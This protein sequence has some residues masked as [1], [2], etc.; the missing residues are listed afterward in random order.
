MFLKYATFNFKIIMTFSLLLIVQ[1]L[2]SQNNKI[3]SLTIV[4][5]NHKAKD[6]TR[7]GILYQM[8]FS[9]F[10]S[11]EKAAK[12]Y[13]QEAEQLSNSLNY[14]KGKADVLQMKGILESRKS[15]YATSDKYFFKALEIY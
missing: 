11:D 2:Y 1:L 10:H 12:K 13:I 6:T 14:P 5:Q 7:V 9:T 8:A 15:N 4:L 3:D